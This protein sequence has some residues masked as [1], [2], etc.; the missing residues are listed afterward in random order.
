MT[1]TYHIATEIAWMLCNTMTDSTL[2]E[3]LKAWQTE[4]R[5]LTENEYN[6]VYHTIIEY[7]CSRLTA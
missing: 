2:E 6:G 4:N 7:G 3:A 5:E 1:A